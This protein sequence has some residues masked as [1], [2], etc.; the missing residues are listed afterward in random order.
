MMLSKSLYTFNTPLAAAFD[1]TILRQHDERLP[2]TDIRKFIDSH[3]KERCILREHDVNSYI[4]HTDNTYSRTFEN[5]TKLCK[6]PSFIVCVWSVSVNRNVILSYEQVSSFS[7]HTCWTTTKFIKVSCLPEWRIP[8]V[9]WNLSLPR[10]NCENYC[11]LIRHRTKEFSL[12]FMFFLWQL[13]F[14]RN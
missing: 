10:N 1:R 7:A 14:Y 5:W 9:K 3:A 6:T 12:H 11:R 8:T 4:L 2:F 13:D